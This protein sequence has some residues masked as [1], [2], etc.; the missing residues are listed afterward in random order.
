[1]GTSFITMFFNKGSEHVLNHFVNSNFA[2][3]H[4]FCHENL[5]NTR[6]RR[7]V[8]IVDKL[9]KQFLNNSFVAIFHNINS[10][11]KSYI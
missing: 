1:M 3:R 5:Q 10:F 8:E 9:L 2:M 6:P 11:Y 7:S 4:K